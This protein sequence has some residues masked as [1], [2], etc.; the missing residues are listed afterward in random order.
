MLA[1]VNFRTC[2]R[3]DARHCSLRDAVRDR[4]GR[5]RA[6]GRGTASARPSPFA[7]LATTRYASASCSRARALHRPRRGLEPMLDLVHVIAATVA[8]LPIALQSAW[9]TPATVFLR[10]SRAVL[11]LRLDPRYVLELGF[12]QLVQ[13]VDHRAVASITLGASFSIEMRKHASR[14]RSGFQ[15]QQQQDYSDHRGS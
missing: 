12:E 6:A 1:G 7:T 2:S 3:T 9:S 5:A 11:E 8:G 13:P 4:R 10:R 15:T 14:C